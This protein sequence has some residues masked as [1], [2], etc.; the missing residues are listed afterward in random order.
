[1]EMN[2]R[3]LAK[4]YKEMTLEEFSI[5]KAIEEIEE[6]LETLKEAIIT[7]GEVKFPKIGIFEILTRQPRMI[8]N[9]VTREL[10]KIYPKKIVRF[11]VSKKMK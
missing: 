1:M 4:L 9:P 11:R 6:F 7:D 5:D 2:K 3:E 10:M 8:S